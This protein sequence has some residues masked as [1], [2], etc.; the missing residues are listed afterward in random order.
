MKSTMKKT[1]YSLDRISDVGELERE[2]VGDSE[3]EDDD[4]DSWEEEEEETQEFV[5]IDETLKRE[6]LDC[7][8]ILR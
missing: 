4:G 7:E 2:D 3:R 6:R 8:S 5:E 1:I